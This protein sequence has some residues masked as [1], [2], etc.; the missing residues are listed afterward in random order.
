MTYVHQ[1]VQQ[2]RLVIY[3][4]KINILIYN[5]KEQTPSI[6]DIQVT[7]CIIYLGVKITNARY[8]NKIFKKQ[9]KNKANEFAN[10][11]YNIVA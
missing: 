8:C 9:R 1:V 6:E 7:Q 2:Y 5:T 11:T 4:E 3:E 10:R